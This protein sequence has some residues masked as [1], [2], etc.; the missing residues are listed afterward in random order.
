MKEF[1]RALKDESFGYVSEIIKDS[2]RIL[3]ATVSGDTDSVVEILHDINNSEIPI[4]QYWKPTH[5][6]SWTSSINQIKDL[7]FH[8]RIV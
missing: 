2:R 8:L 4:L 6:S 1:E 7:D 5:Y 3:K